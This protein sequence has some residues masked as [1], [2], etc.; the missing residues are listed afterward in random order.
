M[1][2]ISAAGT[3]EPVEQVIVWPI[4]EKVRKPYKGDWHEWRVNWK[5]FPPDHSRFSSNDWAVDMNM[6]YLTMPPHEFKS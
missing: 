4:K 6:V 2:A 5:T 3:P 1:D